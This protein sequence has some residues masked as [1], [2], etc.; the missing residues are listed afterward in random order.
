MEIIGCRAP[1][2]GTSRFSAGYEFLYWSFYCLR[3]SG[4]PNLFLEHFDE[5]FQLPEAIAVSGAIAI[6]STVLYNV[7]QGRVKFINLGAV[8][9]TIILLLTGMIEFAD[10]LPDLEDKVVHYA[11]FVLILSFTYICQLVFWGAF[12]RMFNV[13]DGKRMMGSVDMG[14]DFSSIVGYFSIPVLLNVGFEARSLY[15]FG[16][17]SISVYLALFIIMARRYFRKEEMYAS[18]EETLEKLPFRQFFANRFIFTMALFVI[19]SL[20]TIN[21][22]DFSFYNVS[23]QQFDQESLPYFLSFFEGTIVVFAFFF[24]TFATDR[25]VKEY[26]LRV[27]LLVT[28]AVLLVFT[29]AAIALGSYFGFDVKTSG[30]ENVVYFFMAVA[31][32]RLLVDAMTNAVDQ[33]TVKYYYVPLD[34]RTSIDVKT[35][36]EG[37]TMAVGSLLAGGLIVFI[38]QFP[39][40]NLFS[41]TIF[42]VPLVLIWIAI[43][44]FMYRGYRS[45]LETSLIKNKM[46]LSNI[47]NFREYSLAGILAGNL[48]N[49]EDN[50]VIYN[51]KMLEKMEPLLFENAVLQLVESPVASVRNYARKKLNALEIGGIRREIR[52]LA[53]EA[54]AQ[55]NQSDRLSVSNNGL[56]K[57]SKSSKEADRVLA[58]RLISGS[59][60]SRT[61]FM[62]L[63]LLR[64]PATAVRSEAIQTAARIKRPE[65]WPVLV[66]QLA[67]P[68]FS[69]L[70]TMALKEGGKKVLPYLENA[71]H[72]SG[73]SDVV[74]EKIIQIIGSVGGVEA[75]N[76]LWKKIDYPDK[77]IVQS[78][79]HALRVLNIRATGRQAMHVKELLDVEMSKLLWNMMAMEE[80]PKNIHYEPLNVALKE[81]VEDNRHQITLLLSLLYDAADI[82]L[83]KENLDIGTPDSIQYAVELLDIILDGDLKPKL[84]PLVDDT[85][86]REK[87]ELLM[88][89]FPRENYNSVEVIN[90]LLNRDYNHTNRW[91]KACA[92][93]SKAMVP[94]QDPAVNL[95][96]HMFN[97]DKMLKELAAW[98]VFNKGR[99]VYES[100]LKRLSPEEKHFL[101]LTVQNNKIVEGLDDGYFMIVEMGM[102]LKRVPIFSGIPGQSIACLAD[103]VTPLKLRLG[104]T[105]EASGDSCIY[106]TA[107]GAVQLMQGNKSVLGLPRYAVYGD[108]FQIEDPVAFSAIQ[109]TEASVVFK[110]ETADFYFAMASH[111]EL[112]QEILIALSGK[113]QKQKSVA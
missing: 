109:A 31:M 17:G 111:P 1:R 69:H 19:V 79:L 35:K 55:A 74:M 80:I 43:V 29:I 99:E 59:E 54:E 98:G 65:T 95:I 51:L 6:L 73:Q 57:L 41:M 77:K 103:I 71:F 88:S 28:P 82:Q 10:Y 3:Y 32:C 24:T 7:F 5:R 39:V 106:I 96:S 52:T 72:K 26:G 56:M 61:I 105:T 70:A 94:D 76:L 12:S 45:M 112:A 90:Y 104:E 113:K 21:F 36:L 49:K 75:M 27:S 40:F 18:E 93:Y 108:L 15:T 4:F 13:R 97:P 85:S 92:L 101:D 2:K 46:L 83:M 110:I 14:M 48:Q 102:I 38:N 64:D 60:H 50:R 20:V 42:I 100:T 34:K 87:Q 37:T 53:G 107:L 58:A 68:L 81:E 8:S 62:L 47:S 22:V 9:L 66:E 33:P 30:K 84:I 89:Y 78:T 11:A 23:V 91:T 44:Y 63:E 16:L 86:L 25:I 67:F